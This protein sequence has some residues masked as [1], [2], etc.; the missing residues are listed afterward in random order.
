METF[1]TKVFTKSKGVF[2][3]DSNNLIPIKKVKLKYIDN[4]ERYLKIDTNKIYLILFENDKNEENDKNKENDKNINSIDEILAEN[5]AQFLYN[6]NIYNIKFTPLIST[7]YKDDFVF[8]FNENHLINIYSRKNIPSSYYQ[9]FLDDFFENSKIIS[10]IIY[11]IELNLYINN[12][13]KN[14]N[15]I[16]E[17]DINNLTY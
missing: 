9:L 8:N 15:I 11:R 17:F 6:T 12:F 4:Y 10:H 13:K 3:K 2:E 7:F 1:L 5:L 14:K 16:N